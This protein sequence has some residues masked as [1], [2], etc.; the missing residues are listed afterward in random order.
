MRHTMALNMMAHH[1]SVHCTKVRSIWHALVAVL[2]LAGALAPAAAADADHGKVLFQACAA[3]HTD[4]A[5]PLGPNLRGVF[6]RKSA[7]IEDYRYSGPMLRANV[8]WD[9][10]NLKAYISDPQK[11]V[12]GN[13][14][15]F[16]G[17]TNANELD[18]IVAYLKVYK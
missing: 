7:T 2:M 4:G 12:P 6:G 16:G 1:T 3:C 9:E 17:V 8:V 11:K 14:M 18:D 13:R 10:A 5:N 15:P